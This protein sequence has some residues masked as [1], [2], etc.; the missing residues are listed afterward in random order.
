MVGVAQAPT[1]AVLTR[2]P[3]DA[4]KRRIFDALGM[5]TDPALLTALLLD[6]LDAVLAT[7]FRV[8]VGVEPATAADQVRALLPPAVEVVGQGEGD[9]GDRMR[10]LMHA[11][12]ARGASAVI[13]VGSDLPDLSAD[14]LRE[15][16][17]LLGDSPQA[18]VL[19]PAVDGGYYLVGAS[20]VPDIFTGIEWGSARVL[21][22]TEAAAAE[23]GLVCRYVATLHDVDEPSDLAR[24]RAPRTRAWVAQA[25]ASGQRWL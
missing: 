6:T 5:P 18:V 10:G 9:L 11:A 20:A 14:I 23:A 12:F 1:V 8:L 4:G 15:A 16:A 3:S 24:V 22:Q 19:G 7:G 21:R 25:R 17:R 2:A 13:L